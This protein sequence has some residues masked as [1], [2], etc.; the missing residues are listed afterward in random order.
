MQLKVT[1]T[2]PLVLKYAGVRE[3]RVENRGNKKRG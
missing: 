1:N 2:A 3:L